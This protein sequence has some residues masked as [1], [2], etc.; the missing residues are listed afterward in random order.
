MKILTDPCNSC[1]VKACCK[2]YR[3]KQIYRCGCDVY[4]IYR[5]KIMIKDYDDLKLSFPYTNLR[6]RLRELTKNKLI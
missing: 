2:I 3:D 1:L 6:S 4:E 5:I